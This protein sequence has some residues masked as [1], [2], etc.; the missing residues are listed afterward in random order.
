LRNEWGFIG[1]VESDAGVGRHMLDSKAMAQ[2]VVAG[3]DVWMTGGSASAFDGYKN[4]ATVANAMRESCHRMLYTQLHSNAMNGISAD[5]RIVKIT[6][7]WV[8]AISSA[9]KVVTIV[10]LACGGMALLSFIVVAIAQASKKS[11]NKNQN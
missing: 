1:I 6:P 5:T 2:G 4:N 9:T 3:N 7:W 11:K 10:T 8:D